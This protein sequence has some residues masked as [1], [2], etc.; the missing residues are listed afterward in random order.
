MRYSSKRQEQFAYRGR[1]KVYKV[2]LSSQIHGYEVHLVTDMA[3]V[4]LKNGV[5]KR[6]L[7]AFAKRYAQ[8]HDLAFNP[9]FDDETDRVLY[10]Y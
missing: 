10:R 1:L 9:L 3:R 6:A 7:I 8:A 4:V 2:A 5:N